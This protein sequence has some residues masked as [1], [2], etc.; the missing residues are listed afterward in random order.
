MLL[1]H[2]DPNVR[3]DV[4]TIAQE[5]RQKFDVRAFATH[6]GLDATKGGGVFMWREV[7]SEE[8]SSI[9]RDTLSAFSILFAEPSRF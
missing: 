4:P 3:I 1:P 7:W 6:Y 8:V 2:A 9:Y 5:Q